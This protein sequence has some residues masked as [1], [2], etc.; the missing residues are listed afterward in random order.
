MR[1]RGRPPGARNRGSLDLARY[2]EARFAGMTPGQ[3]LAELAMVTEKERRDA[4]SIELAMATKARRVAQDL[5]CET[6]EAM[7]I[8]VKGLTE[9]MPYVHQKRPIAVDARV[10]QLPT[11]FLANEG[12]MSPSMAHAPGADDDAEIIDGFLAGDD[13]VAPPKSHDAD[14]AE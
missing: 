4:G 14:K 11:M 8:L 10:Q 9:L 6:K 1:R 7:A 2:L 5:G 13:Q 3:Q 12:D